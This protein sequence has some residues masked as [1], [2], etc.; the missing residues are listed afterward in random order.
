MER[1]VEARILYSDLI[2]HTQFVRIANKQ[3]PN[4]AGIRMNLPNN[5]SSEERTDPE[6]KDDSKMYL[7]HTCHPSS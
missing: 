4:R 6:R 1:Q 3:M 7:W 5:R 2:E